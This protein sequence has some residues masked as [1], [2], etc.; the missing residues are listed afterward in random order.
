M[1]TA[2]LG[3]AAFVTLSLH[4]VQLG[5]SVLVPI[6]CKQQHR[7]GGWLGKALIWVGPL[8]VAPVDP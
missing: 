7:L 4:S 2:H 5:V 1:K 8:A 6:Y 3:P